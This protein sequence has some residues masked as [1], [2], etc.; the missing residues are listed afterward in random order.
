MQTDYT[1]LGSLLGR[2]FLILP[3]ENISQWNGCQE[4]I[5]GISDYDQLGELPDYSEARVASFIKS[6]DLQYGLF[7]S[8]STKVEVFKKEDAVILIE[9]LYFNQ[10]WDY[11]QSMKL[12]LLDHTELTFSLENGKLVILDATEDGKSI[13][14]SQPAGVF[15]SRSDGVNSYAIVSLVNGTYQVKRVE[16][17][18]SISN[19]T[20]LLEGIEISL[21]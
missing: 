8:M 16:V 7:W 2:Q 18:V 21:S 9:G 15:S 13:D 11:S 20:I 3:V 4:S 5:E 10:S 17:A 14:S 6:K 1:Y 19:E 12:S